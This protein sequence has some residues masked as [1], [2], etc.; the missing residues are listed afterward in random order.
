MDF[1]TKILVT[2]KWA[3]AAFTGQVAAMTVGPR[4]AIFVLVI[5]MGIDW[6]TGFTAAWIRGEV[7]SEAG[8]KGFA[9]KGLTLLLIL[10]IYI[11]DQ[12][13]HMDFNLELW[14]AVGYS[15]NEAISIV[16]NMDRAGVYIPAALVAGLQKVKGLG[17]RKA[18]R[19]ELDALR[20]YETKMPPGN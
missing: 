3:I 1:D 13:A 8:A 12:A 7:S 2:I 16:E 17:P 20:D 5:L 15:I 14:G 4:R 10:T 18:T 11:V 19:A 9:K 6:I